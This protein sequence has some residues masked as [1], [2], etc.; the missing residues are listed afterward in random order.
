MGDHVQL[1]N[2]RGRHPLKSDQTGVVTSN[3]G[4]NN[5]S[6]RISGSGFITKRNRAT[7]RKIL[8]MVQTDSL[9]FGQCQNAVKIADMA[10][11]V[12][13]GTAR[14][15]LVTRPANLDHSH[16]VEGGL[17]SRPEGTSH[18]TVLPEAAKRSDS[19]ENSPVVTSVPTQE[20][21]GT[22]TGLEHRLQPGL[23]D[24][25]SSLESQVDL[26]LT[27]ITVDDAP[28]RMGTRIRNRP[29]KYQA[30]Q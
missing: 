1:Q 25:E 12:G 18:P 24:T 22:G 16:E 10:E 6:V 17:V 2:L 28:L 9:M 13:Q 30:G 3:N 8:P 29:D 27:G 20:G 26:T 7:L 11:Q 5:F 23:G 19:V 4:F 21:Q 15:E 14:A